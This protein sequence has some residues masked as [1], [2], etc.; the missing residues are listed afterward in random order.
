MVLSGYDAPL[1]AELFDGWHRLDLKA[2]TTLSGDTDRVEVLWSNRP[3]RE[4]DLF[5]QLDSI[6]RCLCGFPADAGVRAKSTTT[7]AQP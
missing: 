3:L 4:P 2:P 6:S 5:D 7:P 1:Y